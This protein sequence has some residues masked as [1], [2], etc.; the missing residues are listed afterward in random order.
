M[1]VGMLGVCMSTDYVKCSH[2]NTDTNTTME[3]PE[4]SLM[5]LNILNGL[6]FVFFFFNLSGGYWW[7]MGFPWVS[8]KANKIFLIS[9]SYVINFI[10]AAKIS[11][12]RDA[13]QRQP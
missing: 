12:M 10:S 5:G 6:I 7:Q 3:R 9:Q 8:L 1:S 2:P 11:H 4:K 13:Q